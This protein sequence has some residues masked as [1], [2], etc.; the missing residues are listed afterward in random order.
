MCGVVWLASAR[1]CWHV[2]R[3]HEPIFVVGGQHVLFAVH[4]QLK[5]HMRPAIRA[6]DRRSE[7]CLTA[8]IPMGSPYCSC[9]LTLRPRAGLACQFGRPVCFGGRRCTPPLGAARPRMGHAGHRRDETDGQR[10]ARRRTSHGRRQDKTRRRCATL[11]G[12]APPELAWTV[13]TVLR[14]HPLDGQPRRLAECGT[15]SVG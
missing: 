9:T 7:S 10:E 8:A 13:P 4:R 15:L 14:H 5:G 2:V 11:W 3:L 12:G 1:T 6:S